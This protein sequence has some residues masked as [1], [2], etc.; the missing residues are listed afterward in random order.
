MLIAV[1]SSP[2]KIFIDYGENWEKA[3]NN[4]VH[5]WVAQVT[6]SY[7]PVKELIANNDTRTT[8]EQETNP[9]PNNILLLCYAS[10]II[11]GTVIQ[12]E[13]NVT[14]VNGTRGFIPYSKFTG[15]DENL[16]PCDIKERNDKSNEFIIQIEYIEHIFLVTNYPRDSIVLTI[17]PYS[18]DIHLKGVFRH[19]IEIDDALFPE[20]WKTLHA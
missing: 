7:S 15:R 19:F 18:S 6:D 2:Q 20:S 16:L 3:W 10:K 9:Y 11:G 17:K 12:G 13:G 4:H 8:E 14:V 1:Y 5:N